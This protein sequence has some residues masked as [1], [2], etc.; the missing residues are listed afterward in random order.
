MVKVAKMRIYISG[1]GFRKYLKEIKILKLCLSKECVF[2]H[3]LAEGI[4]KE[5]F[6][7]WCML[8]LVN[9]LWK[10]VQRSG[11]QCILLQSHRDGCINCQ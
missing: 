4:R 9:G 8:F 7:D 3:L 5:Y 2:I 6:G 11:R 1:T 10:E